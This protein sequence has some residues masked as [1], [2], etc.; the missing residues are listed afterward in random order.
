MIVRVDFAVE[1]FLREQNGY[2]GN[3]V[4]DLTLSLLVFTRGIF[5]GTTHDMLRLFFGKREKRFA[6]A[7]GV[8]RGGFDDFIRFLTLEEP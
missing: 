7:G 6:A 2:V 8:R 3:F 1:H 5:F 4:F